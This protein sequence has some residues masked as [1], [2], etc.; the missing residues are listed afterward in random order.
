MDYRNGSFGLLE[1]LDWAE[2]R[3]AAVFGGDDRFDRLRVKT[4]VH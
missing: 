3:W 1:E 4:P 2:A